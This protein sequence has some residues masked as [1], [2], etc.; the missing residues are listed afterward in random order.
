MDVYFSP[1]IEAKL[2]QLASR[3][4]K[5]TAHVIEEAVDRM[6]EYDAHFLAA[7]EEGRA[8]ALRGELIEH[9]AVVERVLPARLRK[10][11]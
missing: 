11:A 10:A 7:V 4:G 5:N 3:S 2:E 1:D 9:D 6:L 8:A